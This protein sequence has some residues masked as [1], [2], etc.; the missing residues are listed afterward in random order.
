M[1]PPLPS[2]FLMLTSPHSPWVFH[3]I[4][5]Y[6][7]LCVCATHERNRVKFVFFPVTL[8]LCQAFCCCDKN[9]MVKPTHR[10]EFIWSLTF[11]RDTSPCPPQWGNVEASRHGGKTGREFTSQTTNSKQR[12]HW[13]QGE[14]WETPSQS[15]VAFPPLRPHLLALPQTV[16]NCRPSIQSPETYG[17]HP[18]R[19]TTP[20]LIP[21]SFQHPPS[22][23]Q[24]PLV[25]CHICA[26]FLDSTYERK[27]MILVHLTYFVFHSNSWFQAFFWK[28]YNFTL[29]YSWMKLCWTYTSS[30]IHLSTDG[31]FA[32]FYTL[33]LCIV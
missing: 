1:L 12:G 9:T 27:Y 22:P 28:W 8:C 3:V 2:I 5:V 14:S 6:A 25:S 4:Y 32:Y 10:R 31:H 16:T 17:G 19:T 23:P 13:K 18:I 21:F 24:S 33:L 7:C 30:S 29:H 20:C 15:S 11:Q 26:L